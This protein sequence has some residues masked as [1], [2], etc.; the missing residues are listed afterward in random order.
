M[1]EYRDSI[2]WFLLLSNKGIFWIKLYL[3]DKVT[4]QRL[5][6]VVPHWSE[7]DPYSDLEEHCESGNASPCE[8][9]SPDC[10]Y[11]TK[12]GGHVLRK[13]HRSYSCTRTRR[14]ST[15]YTFY[16]DMRSSPKENIK[17]KKKKIV[18][19]KEPSSARLKSQSQIRNKTEQV[20]LNLVQSYPMYHGKRNNVDQKSDHESE[21]ELVSD[22]D[23][24]PYVPELDTTPKSTLSEELK[25]DIK[26]KKK[27]KLVTKTYGIKNPAKK[28]AGKRKYKCTSCD[29]KWNSVAELNRHFKD[30]HPPL[31]CKICKNY[32]NTPSTLT[33]HMFSHRELKYPC[34]YC[35]KWFPFESDRDTHHISHQTLKTFACI[36]PNCGKTFFF[37]GDLTKHVKIHR[38]VKWKCQHCPYVPKDERNLKA[39]QRL[40]SN[41][42][43]YICKNCLQL[44]KYNEQLKWHRAKP[45]DCEHFKTLNSLQGASPEY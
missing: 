2:P 13:R 15:G 45:K 14:T 18:P 28:F 20:N 37:K 11:F 5:T 9:V 33:R 19:K 25:R 4:L 3:I 26:P 6:K 40:H 17:P 36:S 44:F 7:L 38:K 43:P 34:D 8:P 10:A 16:C 31:Q 41:L 21:S 24:I 27:G 30:V 12:I 29:S 35:P 42:K 32:L 1:R 22:S 39:H 23:T